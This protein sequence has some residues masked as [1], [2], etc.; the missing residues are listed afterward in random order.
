[1]KLSTL[2]DYLWNN[3]EM[4]PKEYTFSRIG[5]TIDSA[6]DSAAA[7][8]LTYLVGLLTWLGMDEAPTSFV[9]S[10][11]SAAG[12]LQLFIPRLTGNKKHKKPFI[13]VNRL[14]SRPLMAIA[15]ILPFITGR[16]MLT[17]VLVAVFYFVT[18]VT[19]NLYTPLYQIWLMDCSKWGGGVGRFFGIKDGIVNVVRLLA[20][21]VAAFI[22]AKFVGET[23]GYGYLSFGL[24]ALL[25]VLIALPTLFFIKEPPVEHKPKEKVNLLAVTKEMFA[26]P[27]IRRYLS[28]SFI[29]SPFHSFTN[30]IFGVMQIQRLKLGLS[31]LSIL[32]VFDLVIESVMAPVWGRI[33]D[34]IGMRRVL[35]CG[36]TLIAASFLPYLFGTPANAQAI[37]VISVIISSLGYSAFGFSSFA[38]MFETYPEENRSSYMV[39]A[40][41]I[42]SFLTYGASLL[43]TFFLAIGKNF[44]LS[45]GFV[46]LNIFSIILLI[47]FLGE[48]LSVYMLH[49]ARKDSAEA[50]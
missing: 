7:A 6:C 4:K 16:N 28:Y 1:M 48:M 12:L 27:K 39:C 9:V 41:T 17:A 15:F 26:T 40:N 37:A 32:T 47:T 18:S 49:R 23:E 38:Y 46:N 2:K 50:I 44:S 25:M 20:Y 10:L 35:M 19:T 42:S 22:T 43:A 24:L 34:K 8:W 31:F 13:F 21:L 5:F 33:S 29:F 11:T 30:V 14:L 36:V 45:L 3:K